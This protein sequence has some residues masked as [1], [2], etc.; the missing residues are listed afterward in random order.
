MHTDIMLTVININSPLILVIV[1]L[2]PK[3][4]QFSEEDKFTE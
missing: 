3:I 4:L 1:N 2:L